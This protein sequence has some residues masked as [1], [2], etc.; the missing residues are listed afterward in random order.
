MKKNNMKIQIS[1]KEARKIKGKSNWS[2]LVGEQKREK[3][4][5]LKKENT[6]N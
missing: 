3:A 4:K 5:I 2:K 6:N 1:L